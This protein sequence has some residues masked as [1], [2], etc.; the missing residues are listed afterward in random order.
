[1][2]VLAEGRALHR[3]R[4]RRARARLASRT[5]VVRSARA[6]FGAGGARP[7]RGRRTC[8]KVWLCCSSSDM[9]GFVKEKGREEREKSTGAGRGGWGGRR[10]EPKENLPS[11]FQST[12]VGTS[13]SRSPETAA[14]NPQCARLASDQLAQVRRYTLHKR[15]CSPVSL[16]NRLRGNVWSPCFRGINN[17]PGSR[18]LSL[19]VCRQ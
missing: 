1:M 19:G 9:A 11:G 17:V 7:G 6:D 13:H 12:A 4:R 3:E 15:R 8:S 18:R 2:A 14:S 10:T 5:R 16:A